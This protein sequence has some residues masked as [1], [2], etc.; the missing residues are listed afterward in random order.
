MRTLPST[1][2]RA[3]QE[4]YH[5]SAFLMFDW[6]P[7]VARIDYRGQLAGVVKPDWE[8]R[9]LDERSMTE[10]LIA[11]LMGPISEGALRDD[12][13]IN[14]DDWGDG[15]GGDAR[16]AAFIVQW[17]GLDQVDW[18]HIVYKATSLAR[19]QRFRR[20]VVAIANELERIEVVLQPEL[21]RLAREV[22]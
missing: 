9:D 13:P 17:L 14:P 3:W 20:L 4:A 22:T 6:P 7:L 15:A 2:E 1:R 8:R 21:I 19:Q 11:T 5:A 10:S 12:W 18:L 16:Q